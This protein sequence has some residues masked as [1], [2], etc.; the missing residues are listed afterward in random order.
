MK[1][2]NDARNEAKLAKPFFEPLRT[3]RTQRRTE[4]QK[5]SGKGIQAVAASSHFVIFV[6][7]VV[8]FIRLAPLREKHKSFGV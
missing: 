5:N 6:Y 4:E 2:N 8:Q 3:L 7:F 1:S